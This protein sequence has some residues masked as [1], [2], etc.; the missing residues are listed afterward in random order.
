MKTA[1]PTWGCFA[2]LLLCQIF[3]L[4]IYPNFISPNELSRLLLISAI[5]DDHSVQIDHAIQR[6]GETQDKAEFNGHF[7]TPTIGTSLIGL[8]V[9]A[10]LTSTGHQW[11]APALLTWLHIFC[12][13]IP[14]LL[15]LIPLT[16]FWKRFA[17]ESDLSGW[18]FVYL[19]GTIV[20]TYSSQF[21]SHHLVGI[22][23]FS[24]FYCI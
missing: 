18:I 1:L 7:F 5:W 4:R 21:I 17:E 10:V 11:S 3:F 9:Y 16:S 8:P 23:L 19:F 14:G 15:F 2:L 13:T 24:S 22:C 20:F 12:V 6:Y